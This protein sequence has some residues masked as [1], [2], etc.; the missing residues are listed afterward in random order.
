MSK[1]SCTINRCSKFKINI[2]EKLAIVVPCYKEEAVL[3]ETTK[4]LSKLLDELIR[5][6]Q[7]SEES[8]ILYVNDGSRDQTWPLI[9]QFHHA[10]KYVKGVN[11][12]GNVGHQNALW[13]G[14]TVAKDYADMIVSI[15]A[16]LQDDVNSI[17]EM[18]Q[19]YHQGY[20]IVYGVRKERK[21]D[22]WFKKNTALA[23]YK[24]MEKMG[25]KTV[26][27]HADFR[28]MS[29]RALE[30]LLQF[31]ERNLFIRGL[32]PLVGYKTTK[33][34]YDRA[35]R[36]AGE[37]K[38]PLSKMLNFAIDGITSF[39]VKPIRLILGLGISFIVVAFCVLIWTLY[40]Y[41]TGHV[42]AGWSSLMLSIW[43]CSGCVLTCMGIVGEYIGKIYVE[44]KE[45]PRFNI[46]TVLM[47]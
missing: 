11:L 38:Y 2:M 14:M 43:F 21:T 29:K 17:K 46:E 24:V 13:A 28:L 37:S 40:S 9:Y 20:D 5:D 47:D 3:A 44:C 22:T 1:T 33:V 31:K 45:R 15:D 10:N 39:S 42:V 36:F 16:D 26:Y 41:F 25:T 23:F 19:Q 34:Y 4:R 30:Y 12:A 6:N 7:V 32:V 27:N 35:E 18:V 8:F